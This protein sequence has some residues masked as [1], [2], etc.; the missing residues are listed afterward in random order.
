MDMEEAQE[1]VN[2]PAIAMIVL[3][4]LNIL[5]W[6]AWTGYALFI[7]VV[8]GGLNAFFN[9]P[10]LLESESSLPALFGIIWG[11]LVQSCTCGVDIGMAIGSILMIAAGIKLRSL[12]GKGIVTLGVVAGI[13]GP[14]LSIV[15]G[16]LASVASFACCGLLFGQLPTLVVLV[17]NTMAG[18]W[19]I[20]IMGDEDV[21]A[22]FEANAT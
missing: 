19:A 15:L 7:I 21:A 6:L 2:P 9:L 10:M 22:A 14:I 12:S 5:F 3:G 4:I 18:I 16:L 17:L 8:G 1:K 20:M 13:V 11:P